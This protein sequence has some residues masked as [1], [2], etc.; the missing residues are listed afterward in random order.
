MIAYPYSQHRLAP[1]WAD[2][3]ARALAAVAVTALTLAIWRRS[4]IAWSELDGLA[5]E[6]VFPAAL[7]FVLAF[8]PPPQVLANR[9]AKDLLVCWTALA[10]LAGHIPL[11][12]VAV[13][14][15][16]ALAVAVSFTPLASMWHKGEPS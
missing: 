14:A 2:R 5:L 16:L 1:A 13:P 6:V 15:L 4:P 8:A 9:I 11:M 12:L 10:A 7:A 3:K